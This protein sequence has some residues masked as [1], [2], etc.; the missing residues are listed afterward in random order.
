MCKEALAD[1]SDIM[2]VFCKFKG[3]PKS[4]SNETDPT[5]SKN[6]VSGAKYI[7]SKPSYKKDSNIMTNPGTTD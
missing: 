5:W 2:D 1:A 6:K 4:L 7:K 3:Y